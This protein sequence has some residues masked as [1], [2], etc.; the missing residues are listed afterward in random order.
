MFKR[1]KLRQKLVKLLHYFFVLSKLEIDLQNKVVKKLKK[2]CFYCI[3]TYVYIFSQTNS[4]IANQSLI[5]LGY[6][7]IEDTDTQKKEGG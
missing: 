2:S 5:L 6:T 7:I 4:L 3:F 1:L